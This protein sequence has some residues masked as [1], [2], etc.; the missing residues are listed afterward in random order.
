MSLDRIVIFKEKVPTKENIGMV[1]EDYLG[2]LAVEVMWNRERYMAVLKGPGSNP[3]KRLVG[4]PFTTSET[5]ERWIEVVLD[6]D[7]KEPSVDVLTR[8]QDEITNNIADGFAKL[9]ARYWD[10]SLDD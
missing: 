5:S 7:S 8:R 9:L 3:F 2:E 1:L 10:G 6:L 4:G